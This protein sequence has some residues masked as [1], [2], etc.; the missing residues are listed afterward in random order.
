[1]VKQARVDPRAR[2]EEDLDGAL[3][4]RHS[5]SRVV[6]CVLTARGRARSIP[7]R[8]TAASAVMHAPRRAAGGCGSVAPTR[9][10]LVRAEGGRRSG[11]AS[12]LVQTT[13]GAAGVRTGAF[14]RSARTVFGAS[15]GVNSGP[16]YHEPM[17][18]GGV[19]L[20][21]GDRTIQN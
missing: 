12:L 7:A 5:P 9:A 20:K 4:Q 13:V 10:P 14:S 2:P 1:M 16:L 18:V 15:A 19:S 6:Y 21:T 17:L 11:R 8:R 3:D